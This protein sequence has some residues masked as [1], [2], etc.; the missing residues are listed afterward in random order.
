MVSSLWF[1]AIGCILILL[2]DVCRV[3]AGSNGDRPGLGRHEFGGPDSGLPPTRI[4]WTTEPLRD[5][6]MTPS[7]TY[8]GKVCFFDTIEHRDLFDANHHRPV[9]VDMERAGARALEQQGRRLGQSGTGDNRL[10][11]SRS[12]SCSSGDRNV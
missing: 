9:A 10:G 6:D 12:G 11:Q 3:L 7:S 4:V 1:V 2:R 8:E 5:E